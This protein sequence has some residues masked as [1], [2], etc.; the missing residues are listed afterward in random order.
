MQ[1]KT[2]QR[3]SLLKVSFDN[4]AAKYYVVFDELHLLA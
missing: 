2:A 3:S 1:M 4:N